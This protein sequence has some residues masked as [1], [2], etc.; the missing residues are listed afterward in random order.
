MINDDAGAVQQSL[1]VLHLKRKSSVVVLLSSIRSIFNFDSSRDC[2]YC[3]SPM[4][5]KRESILVRIIA[6][7]FLYYTL[8]YSVSVLGVAAFDRVIL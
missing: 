5:P 8:P 3:G 4:Y 1:G 6:M 2:I 7:K